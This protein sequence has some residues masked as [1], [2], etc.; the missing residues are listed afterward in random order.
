MGISR[1]DLLAEITALARDWLEHAD[2][3]YPDG[4]SVATLG[5]VYGLELPDGTTVVASSCSDD[6]HWVKAGLFRAAML[7]VEGDYTET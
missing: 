7:E 3:W 4:F 6:R 1:D 2:E 5:V